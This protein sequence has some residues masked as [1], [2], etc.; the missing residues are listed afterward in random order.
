MDMGSSVNES[1]NGIFESSELRD[2]ELAEDASVRG[3]GIDGSLGSDTDTSKT[4]AAGSAKDAI[5]RYSVR[6]SATFKPVSVTKN[7]LA[8]TTAVSTP[9]KT[10]GD[11]GS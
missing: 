10:T 2:P 8:K 3:P 4:D 11:K 6:K 5:P 1:M 7:L 9:T